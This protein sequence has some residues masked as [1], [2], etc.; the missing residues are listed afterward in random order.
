[1]TETTFTDSDDVRP[2]ACANC[3]WDGLANQTRPIQD[4]YE[5]IEPGGTV[6]IGE[7]PECHALAYLAEDDPAEANPGTTRLYAVEYLVR[8]LMDGGI[9][10]TNTVQVVAKDPT[11]ANVLA[12]NWVHEHDSYCDER[13]DPLVEIIHTDAVEVGDEEQDEEIE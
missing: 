9:V 4:L 6:P 5:R 10:A 7:C 12:T 13:I 2:C 8:S 1:M 3:A 11:E